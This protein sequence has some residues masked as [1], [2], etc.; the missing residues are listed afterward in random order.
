MCG[1]AGI[2][3]AD[4]APVALDT[5][6]RMGGAI[7]HRGPDGY[8]FLVGQG[9]GLVHVRLSIVDIEGGAQPM[10]TDDGRLSIVFNGEIFNH[11]E[12]RAELA[13]LGHAFRTRCDTEVLLHG[14]EQW[15]ESLLGRL[16]GQFA[17]VILDR[18]TRRAFLARDPL[19]VRPL[20]YHDAAGTL[21]FG[22]EVKAL[23][24]SGMVD[25]RLD[26]R[27]LDQ[28]FTTWAA[29]APRTVFDGV[30]QLPPGCC[31]VWDAGELR[32][33]R[34]FELR[35]DEGAERESPDAVE[36]L[37]AALREAVA[38]RLRADVPVGGYLS[39]GLDS[40]ITCQLAR[41]SARELRTFSVTFEDPLLDESVHQ[42]RVA[43]WLG[44]RHVTQAI[45][46]AMIGEVFPDVIWHTE[47]PMVRT[48][49]APLY[50]LSRLTRENGIKVV[51]SGEGSDEFFLGYD[52]FKET[53][54]RL[55]CLRQ[56]DS[57][58][59]PRLFDQLYPYL[60]GG[61]PGG[62]FWRRSFLDAG[63]A[64]D[65]FFSHLP[66]IA[67][68]SFIKGF[69]SGDVRAALTGYDARAELLEALPEAF[70]SLTPMRRANQLEVSTLLS[71][72][73]LSSQGD[74]VAMAHGVEGRFPFL[75]PNVVS[76]ALRLPQRSK[77]R[78]LREK[79]ILRRWA[80]SILP[81]D[82]SGRTKQPYR[83]PDAVAFFGKGAPAY[84]A[85]LLSHDALRRTGVFDPD[86]VLR[87]VR[88]CAE[89]RAHSV[90]EN[91]AA[92]A[93]LSTQLW[94]DRF[95]TTD[96]ARALDPAGADVMLLEQEADAPMEA[97]LTA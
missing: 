11:V 94:L 50:L 15:G 39:G 5:L 12:L 23:L 9:A 36:R 86:A 37:D 28:V 84:V 60:T 27:G 13:A 95:R 46:P 51:L 79:D 97:Q 88:R 30:R 16:N 24:A 31:A 59:R 20:H 70:P 78:N 54:V 40:S 2:L 90:R 6:A 44:T 58:R 7:R 32:V 4:G 3:R 68:T 76:L 71:A 53:A 93:V 35:F 29:V 1:L 56:P 74:R 42:K 26:L 10:T 41:A 87:L 80:Q 14:F 18:V 92:V 67:L 45:T 48:A 91:Q 81:P 77:L 66:R 19:G 47:T 34:Y 63:P 22:S 82:V 65:P 69:Y 33:R 89:G 55:F 73:L 43:A 17:F 61:R 8:G 21:V 25:A 52:L 96:G 38:L 75:D 49:P 62:E 83:A 72:Y 64:D 85:D 57:T